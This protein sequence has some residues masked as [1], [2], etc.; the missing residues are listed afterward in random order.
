MDLAMST[1]KSTR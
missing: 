1:A